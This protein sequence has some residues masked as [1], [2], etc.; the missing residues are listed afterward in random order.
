MF[1]SI[2]RYR[3]IQG[4]I[5]ELARLVDTG[6]AEEIGAQPGFVSYEFTDCGEGE[7]ATISLFRKA[8]E[9]EMSRDLAQHWTD[10]NLDDFEFMRTEALHGEILVSRAAPEMLASAHAAGERKFAS[11]RRYTLRSG[12][13]EE[14]MHLVDRGFADQIQQLDGFEA[15]H[16]LDCGRGEI[17]SVSLLRD[18]SAAEESDDSALA[19][20]R[21]KLGGFDI[22]GTEMLAGEVLVSRAMAE[23]LEPAHG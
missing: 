23:L 11:L 21:E 3:L 20:V 1:A 6:F 12:S 2:R 15:Y 4:P 10:E 17:L 18:Q 7:I 8:F 19:F 22:E 14:L 13:I 5:D 9:A 16:A